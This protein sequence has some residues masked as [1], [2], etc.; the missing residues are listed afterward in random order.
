MAKFYLSKKQ[1]WK[2]VAEDGYTGGGT[3]AGLIRGLQIELGANT[4]DGIMGS[5]TRNSFNDY[6]GGHLNKDNYNKNT[7]IV[8]ILTGGFYCRGI[9]PGSFTDKFTDS[10]VNAVKQLQ[11]QIGIEIGRAHV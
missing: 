1:G 6:F 5:E 7:N 11:E 8:K 9:E 2:N 3:V 4:I 10:V